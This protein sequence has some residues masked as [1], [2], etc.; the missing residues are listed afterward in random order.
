MKDEIILLPE[1]HP[2]DAILM[3]LPHEDTDWAYMLDEAKECFYQI[4][5][6]ISKSGEAVILLVQNKNDY[7]Y[8]INKFGDNVFP[9]IIPFNDTWTRDFGPIFIQNGNIPVCLDFK[10]NGW[11]LK[12][13]ADKDNQ[14]TG[15][16]TCKN[17]FSEKVI[18]QNRLNFVLEGGSIE[19]DGNGILLTT[20]YCLLS[21]NRNGE[22]DRPKIENYLKTVLGLKKILW[23]NNKPL[24][25][26]DTDGHID[27]LARFC[28]QK[29]I[30]YVNCNDKTNSN[31]LTLRNMEEELKN[32]SLLNGESYNL[33]PLPLP[34]PII[35]N[36]KQLPATYANFLI[37]NNAVLIPTY[38]SPNDK[39]AINTI[40]S[41]F[42]DRKVIDIDCSALIKQNGSL[43]C[44]TMNLPA[45]SVNFELLKK[46]RMN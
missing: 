28:N 31:Y 46:I 3:A 29:T 23:L 40:T 35:C 2:Q 36:G 20:A 12:F 16:M 6:A 22:W 10:F 34:E 17:I 9:A 30:V 4:I 13:A 21:P 42:P 37:I 26:D 15:L 27:T 24:E 19:T 7:K 43:H 38:K 11:G 45:G 32:F 1:W 39:E 14:V 18:Y 33:L 41:L 5:N 8:A 44:A 25:G